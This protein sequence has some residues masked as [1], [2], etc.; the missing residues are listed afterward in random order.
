MTLSR[1]TPALFCCERCDRT[2]T[3][4]RTFPL[5]AMSVSFH[6]M[7]ALQQSALLTRMHG[8]LPAADAAPRNNVPAEN[9]PLERQPDDPDDE[10]NPPRLDDQIPGED[11]SLAR[12]MRP[13]FAERFNNEDRR[14]R[15]RAIMRQPRAQMR[16]NLPLCRRKSTS[17]P[18]TVNEQMNPMTQKNWDHVTP[19]GS[20]TRMDCEDRLSTNYWHATTIF[21]YFK[22]FFRWKVMTTKGMSENKRMSV[23]TLKCFASIFVQLIIRYVHRR[24]LKQNGLFILSQRGLYHKLENR[25]KERTSEHDIWSPHNVFTDLGTLQWQKLSNFN[26]DTLENVASSPSRKFCY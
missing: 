11:L 6:S 9:P 4:S 23:R 1:D 22:A 18:I 19:T 2:A 17:D 7:T 12:H 20:N 21:H 5:T 16:S 13:G 8:A 14:R 3:I 24:Y 15:R 26:E 10:D 25:V